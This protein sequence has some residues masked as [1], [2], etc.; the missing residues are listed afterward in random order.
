MYVYKRT[1]WQWCDHFSTFVVM[2]IANEL[3]DNNIKLQEHLNG[4]QLVWLL[5][6]LVLKLIH[7]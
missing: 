4:S 1:T 5:C 6:T 2:M 3:L 7:G